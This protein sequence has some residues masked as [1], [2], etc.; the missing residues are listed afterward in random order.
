LIQELESFHVHTDL[1]G[2]SLNPHHLSDIH[3]SL[4]NIADPLEREEE[5]EKRVRAIE[6]LEDESGN[7]EVGIFRISHLGGHRYAGVMIVSLSARRMRWRE[8]GD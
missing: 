5:R 7:G 6:G 4:S 2:D 1:K 8:D 3:P